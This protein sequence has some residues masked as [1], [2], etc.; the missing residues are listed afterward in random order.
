MNN[1][2]QQFHQYQQSEQSPLT[3]T[4]NIVESAVKHHNPNPHLNSLN[5]KKTTTCDVGNT[6]PSLGQAQNCGVIKPNNWIPTHS[7]GSPTAI[8][9]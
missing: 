3:L 8:H 7:T 2:G 1:D 9:I 5:T 4:W 6:G